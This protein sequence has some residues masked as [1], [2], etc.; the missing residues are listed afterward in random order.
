MIKNVYTSH[1]NNAK[2][3]NFTIRTKMRGIDK[4]AA[5]QTNNF[6]VLNTASQYVVVA[7]QR[8]YFN[9]KNSLE[10]GTM[11][12]VDVNELELSK[13]YAFDEKFMTA[14]LVVV[15][16]FDALRD[17]AQAQFDFNGELPTIEQ[18]HSWDAD[19]QTA[20]DL[21][22]SSVD[23]METAEVET[24]T[25]A[26]VETTE[27]AETAA[28]TE[29]TVAD[30]EKIE[31]GMESSKAGLTDWF[32]DTISMR[33]LIKFKSLIDLFDANLTT[34]RLYE[35]APSGYC[36]INDG[37]IAFKLYDDGRLMRSFE[38]SKF[39]EVNIKEIN[40]G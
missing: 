21:T 17:L 27:T 29:L 16:S 13:S 5:A 2:G 12:L 35:N 36:M 19:T 7:G 40:N 28:T 1:N 15:D 18:T 10:A 37:L 9:Y 31:I 20:T 14:D 38:G 3:T 8:Y 25:E 34:F 23:G 39:S 11:T 24:T 32:E 33:T 26:T 6:A 22:T 4:D 30:V